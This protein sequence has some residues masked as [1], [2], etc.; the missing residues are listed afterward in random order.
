MS[1][2]LVGCPELAQ[3]DCRLYPQMSPWSALSDH[4][5]PRLSKVTAVAKEKLTATKIAKLPDG[6]HNDGNNLYLKVSKNGANKS[7]IFRYTSPVTGKPRK[8]GYGSYNT[9]TST[10]AHKLADADRLLLKQGKD[11]LEEQ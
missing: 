9:I 4:L 7:W 11:P 10:I 5:Y 3:I 1:L 8:R 6:L 2:S